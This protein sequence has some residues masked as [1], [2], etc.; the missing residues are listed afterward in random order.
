MAVHTE[1]AP[2]TLERLLS[3]Y[4]FSPVRRVEHATQGIEN[5]N[6]FVA[7]D[8]EQGAV[9]LVVTLFESELPGDGFVLRLLE[10]LA[11]NGLPVP[12]PF[13]TK[14]GEEISLCEDRAAMVV[15]RF[16]GSHPRSTTVEQC[17]QIGAFLG[18]MHLAAQ[19]LVRTATAHPR[20]A[21]WLRRTAR[22]LAP[23]LGAQ[24]KRLLDEASA[25]V[26]AFLSR[27]DVRSLPRGVV[28]GDLFCDNALFEGDQLIAVIDFHHASK[29]MLTFDLA[30]ALNDWAVDTQGV[31]EQDRQSALIEG[32][33]GF[34][35]LSFAEHAYL[36][37]LR[38]YAALCFWLSRLAQVKRIAGWGHTHLPPWRL[39][40]ALSTGRAKDPRWFERLLYVHVGEA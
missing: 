25:F 7:A 4:G 34:R 18:R 1:L 39:D 29:T 2:A 15:Q 35:P 38:V 14:S 13:R 21:D 31:T 19:P 28:H 30:V 33:E 27:S 24:A 32:Y 17:R 16:R 23:M 22:D 3:Q 11:N 12:V 9:E 26:L 40:R 6:F 8:S 37:G 36:D 20:D 10:A 5:S